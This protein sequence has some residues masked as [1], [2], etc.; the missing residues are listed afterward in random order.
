[1]LQDLLSIWYQVNTGRVP[2]IEH[3]AKSEFNFNDLQIWIINELIKTQQSIWT[4]FEVNR[5]YLPSTFNAF[6]TWEQQSSETAVSL[7]SISFVLLG[8]FFSQSFHTITF[9]D[10]PAVV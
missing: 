7:P 6:L 10:N 5:K 8:L 9:I 1:M 4:N 2:L 3:F